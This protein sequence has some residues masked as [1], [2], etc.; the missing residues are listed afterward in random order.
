MTARRGYGDETWRLAQVGDAPSLHRAADLLLRDPD[1][2]NYEGHRARAF[3]LAVEGSADDALAQLN[4]GWTDDWPFPSAYATDVARVRFL[5][6][7]YGKALDALLIA[8]R[9]AERVDG[10]VAALASEC[11]R[12]DP[13][14]LGRALR[15]ALAGG[16]AYQRLE[17]AGAVLRA[18][19]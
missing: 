12:R 18:R 17:N 10:A 16:T 15:V 14:L 6:G 4:E 8:T 2:L 13:T 11:V 3:A 7:D 19:F 5:T 9:G 1:D